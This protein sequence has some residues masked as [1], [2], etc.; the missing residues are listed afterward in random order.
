M[1]ITLTKYKEYEYYINI[2]IIWNS[3]RKFSQL[4]ITL[5]IFL[6]KHCVLGFETSNVLSGHSTHHGQQE[7][8]M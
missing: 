7:S 2:H 6:D 1:K 5:R 8:H 3:D 4:D